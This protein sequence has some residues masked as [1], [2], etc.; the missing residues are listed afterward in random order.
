MLVAATVCYKCLDKPFKQQKCLRCGG[1]HGNAVCLSS[2][3]WR[4]DNAS[5]KLSSWSDNDATACDE[6]E[7]KLFVARSG[8]EEGL[9]KPFVEWMM[10]ESMRGYSLVAHN[11]A[12][13][14]SLYIFRHVIED[15]G[16][17]VDPI[18]NGSKLLQFTVKQTADHPDMQFRAIDSVQFFQ[19]ALKNC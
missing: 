5:C 4:L 10:E 1:L 17:Y 8:S 19:A 7:Q 3:E 18:Y 16:F 2:E 9:F 6:C 13:F 11:G 12:S 14:D 15:F